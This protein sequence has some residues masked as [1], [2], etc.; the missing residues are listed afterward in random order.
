MSETVIG[1][2]MDAKPGDLAVSGRGDLGR[3]RVQF[4]RVAYSTEAEAGRIVGLC[5]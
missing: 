5:K 4:A 2:Y 3:V 1:E